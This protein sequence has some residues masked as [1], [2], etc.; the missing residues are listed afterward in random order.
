M[1]DTRG[2]RDLPL[3]GGLS[4]AETRRPTVAERPSEPRGRVQYPPR[5]RR[6]RKAQGES[7]EAVPSW[8]HA[9][10]LVIPDARAGPRIPA[11]GRRPLDGRVN[12]PLAQAARLANPGSGPCPGLK[13]GL[14]QVGSEEANEALEPL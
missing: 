14:K 7:A 2:V 5:M 1:C 9:F 10:S 13:P 8:Q 3:A 4:T 12:L 11:H 6:R